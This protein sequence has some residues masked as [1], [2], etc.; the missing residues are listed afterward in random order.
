MFGAYRDPVPL[1]ETYVLAPLSQLHRN[2]HPVYSS[3]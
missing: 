1:M 3:R 2:S